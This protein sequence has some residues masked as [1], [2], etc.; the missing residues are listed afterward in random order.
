[1]TVIRI[2]TTAV[3]ALGNYRVWVPLLAYLLLKITLVLVYTGTPNGPLASLWRAIVPEAARG[4]VSHYPGHLLIMPMI[5]GRVE[6]ALDVL[7][8]VV[9]QG[10]TVFLI[11]WVLTQKPLSID[12]AFRGTLARYLPAIGVTAI[13]SSVLYGVFFLPE[14][15]APESVGVPPIVVKGA[16]TIVGLAVQALFI[17]TLPLVLLARASVIGAVRESFS[18]ASREFV[19]TFMIVVV[20]FLLTIPVILL[21]GKAELLIAKLS[22]DILVHVQIARE[23]G[24]WLSTVVLIGGLTAYYLNRKGADAVRAR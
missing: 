10:A 4:A 8:N 21:E 5:L 7:V 1:M 11:A 14:L 18:L 19:T 13:A 16:V 2:F 12:R 22:P 15:V 23:L 3:K 20:P 24:Q 6:I 9:F 17:F